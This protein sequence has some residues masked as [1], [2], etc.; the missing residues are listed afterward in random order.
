MHV[1][2][3]IHKT[4]ATNTANKL[5]G[6]LISKLKQIE[7]STEKAMEIDIKLAL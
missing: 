3:E 5:H 1:L 2:V 6:K 4:Q 7:W